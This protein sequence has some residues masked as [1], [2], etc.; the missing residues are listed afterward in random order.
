MSGWEQCHICQEWQRTRMMKNHMN[1][2]HGS[3]NPTIV[4]QGKYTCVECDSTFCRPY[5]LKRHHKLI[6]HKDLPI[7]PIQ[8]ITE[9][10]K[11]TRT[12]TT[13]INPETI[14]AKPMIDYSKV[15]FRI[16]YNYSDF[17]RERY[18]T[19]GKGHETTKARGGTNHKST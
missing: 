18:L 13:E 6:H 9:F 2:E 4:A 8:M 14:K 19:A 10:R 3:K 16:V 12:K 1:T 7:G 5:N 11:P 15:K 17:Y